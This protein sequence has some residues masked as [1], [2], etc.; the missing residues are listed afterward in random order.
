LNAYRPILNLPPDAPA[1]GPD[2]LTD[3]LVALYRLD[4][5]LLDAVRSV[6]EDTDSAYRGLH[7]GREELERALSRPPGASPF[8]FDAH[9]LSLTDEG[10]G[11]LRTLGEAYS[12][13]DFETDVLLLALAPEFDLRYGRVYAYLQDDATRRLPSVDLALNL[14]C[15]TARERIENR[16]AFAPESDAC[17]TSWSHASLRRRLPKI[18]FASAPSWRFHPDI[19]LD[20]WS[21]FWGGPP[22]SRLETWPGPA[23]SVK[24]HPAGPD[25]EALSGGGLC[26]ERMCFAPT[27]RLGRRPVCCAS[28]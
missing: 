12:L 9:E 3:L 25:P 20:R 7:I 8:A 10:A 19:L 23:G 4:A 27:G 1:P 26:S 2:P 24:L 16:A 11:R 18:S 5:R 22:Y 15:R 14:L 17:T 28:R 13:S 6:P 21:E